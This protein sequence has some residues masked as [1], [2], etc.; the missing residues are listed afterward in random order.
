VIAMPADRHR[1]R[2]RRCRIGLHGPL[3]L[4]ATLA[5]CAPPRALAQAAPPHLPAEQLVAHL[6]SSAEREWRDWGQTTVDARDGHSR[7]ERRGARETDTAWSPDPAQCKPAPR[8]QRAGGCH[9]GRPFDAV[10]RLRRYWVAGLG[11]DAKPARETAELDRVVR[12]EPW[13]A[14]FVSYLM[15]EVGLSR[16]AFP[17][18]DTHSNY[19]RA[20]EASPQFEL[21]QVRDTPLARG[22]LVCGPR[23]QSRDP[24]L[25]SLQAMRTLE[26]L[27][28][29]RASH[30]DLVVAVDRRAREAHVIG[31]NVEDS[32]AMTRIALT[33]DGR[34]IRTLSRPWF[35]IVR[36]R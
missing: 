32:V 16:Q 19:L 30:C 27:R 13:S 20:L 28:V 4:A 21:R 34:A 17:S 15:Q 36:P 29:L 22:D 35:V 5:L 33:D 9:H 23:N 18:D 14:V 3:V 25:L 26:D 1:Q 6:V 7:L 10:D 12:E 8:R 2:A 31:G 24:G 11:P